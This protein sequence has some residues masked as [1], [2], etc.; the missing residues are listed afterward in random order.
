M[1][2]LVIWSA[3]MKLENTY[4]PR[5]DPYMLF[6]LLEQ[7]IKRAVY[8]GGH[9]WGKAHQ[10]S[11][12]LPSPADWRWTEPNNWKPLWT[13]LPE[14]SISSRELLGCGCK[15]R[16]LTALQVQESSPEMYCSVSV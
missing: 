1:I 9:C 6:F 7:H 10:V 16:M 5:E 12:D 13:T 15:K 4:L 3:L 8:Q 14:A 2:V 11:L